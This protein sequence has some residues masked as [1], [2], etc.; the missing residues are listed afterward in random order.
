MG[1]S[2]IPDG[3]HTIT[4]YLVIKDAAKAIEFYKKAFGAETVMVMDGPGGKVMHGEIRIGN[5]MMMLSDEHPDHGHKA[6]L[7]NHHSASMFLYVADVDASFKRAVDAG[8]TV[9]YPLADQFWGDRMG[10]VMDPFGHTWGMATH[11]E[12]VSPEECQR[13]MAEWSKDA[14]ACSGA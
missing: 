11:K 7:P 14:K 5:S 12:D 6:P 3:Y 13:R 2:A 4:P 10:K 8:C 9:M 1:V